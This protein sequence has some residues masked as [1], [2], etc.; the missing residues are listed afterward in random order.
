MQ[1]AIDQFRANIDR[2]RNLGAIHRA[3]KA[4]TTEVI[5]L[6]DILR[7]ELVMAVSALDHYI[8]EIVRIGM[9]EIYHGNRAKTAAFLR[10]SISLDSALQGI[11]TPT[12]DDWLD[13]EIRVRHGW[14]SFQQ[15]DKVADAIRLISDVS[16]WEE[17]AN[18]LGRNS[19]DVKRQLNLIVGRR[20]QI[21]HE[22][23]IN[24]TFPG[25]RW[26]IDE[27]LVDDA[28]SF[29]EQIAETIYQVL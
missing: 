9:L 29:I 1:A 20:N 17:I 12:S 23:D 25:E 11:T 13:N 21:A 15:A 16:L 8:H 28:I 7:A 19:Q 22:A 2:I 4:Q 10:F 5:D 3:L 6:S 24:P 18:Q 27:A 14:Q 26:P